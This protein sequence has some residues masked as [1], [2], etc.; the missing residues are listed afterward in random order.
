MFRFWYSILYSMAN[1]LIFIKKIK[2]A[3]YL[4]WSAQASVNYQ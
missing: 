4:Q 3:W 2:L 1:F